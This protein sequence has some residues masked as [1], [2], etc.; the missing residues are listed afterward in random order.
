MKYEEIET[1]E[2]IKSIQE[3]TVRLGGDD[4]EDKNLE[5]KGTMDRTKFTPCDKNNLGKEICAFANTYGGYIFFHA[6][7]GNELEKFDADHRVKYAQK[8]QDW[9]VNSLQPPIIGAHTKFVDGVYKIYVPQ[10]I[11]KPHCFKD[12]YYYRS[13]SSSLKMPQI[14]VSAMYR[15]QD[16]LAFEARISIHKEESSS[17]L[18]IVIEIE[19]YTN[20]AGTELKIEATIFSNAKQNISFTGD[21]YLVKK[22]PPY[23]MTHHGPDI[24]F[25]GVFTGAGTVKDLILYPRDTISM[26]AYSVPDEQCKLMKSAFIKLDVNF[27]QSPRF[28]CFS[29][30]DVQ[31]DKKVVP[32]ISSTRSEEDALAVYREHLA[33]S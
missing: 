30:F 27:I 20:M 28:T 12:L 31:S 29:V 25:N 32:L 8:I 13:D 6:G 16:I 33:S 1:F 10:S 22:P 23:R 4:G 26:H 14:A 18:S 19:N 9:L 5:F 21:S 24:N 11:V 7:R 15:S 3:D 2:Q 17:Q